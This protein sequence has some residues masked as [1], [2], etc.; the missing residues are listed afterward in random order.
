[1]TVSLSVRV[2]RGLQSV[3]LSVSLA[4]AAAAQPP[5][6]LFQQPPA[7]EQPEAETP[8][9][10]SPSA[11]QPTTPA[12]ADSIETPP[13]PADAATP[14]DEA[15]AEEP[16]I[17]DDA[18]LAFQRANVAISQGDVTAALAALDEAIS[19][20]PDYYDAFL[21][22]NLVYRISGDFEESLRAAAQA[23]A[24]DP[25][26]PNGYLN[27]ALTYIEMKDY[28]KALADVDES[29]KYGPNNPQAF[30]VAGVVHE[31]L[32]DWEKMLD[33]YGKAIEYAA[34]MPATLGDSLMQR[35]IA[36]FHL[37]EY[38]LAKLD[39][40]QAGMYG[41][42]ANG[43]S[44]RWR[45]YVY[46]VQG[47]Y[48]RAIR[49]FD[50]AVKANP[51]NAQAYRNRGMAYLNMAASQPRFHR[52]GLI[53]AVA[54]FN[55]AIRLKPHDAQLYYRRGVAYD[56]LGETDSARSSYQTAVKLDPKLTEAANQLA[57]SQAVEYW[58]DE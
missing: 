53:Q 15:A 14:A 55:Q 28:P 58:Y 37:G 12:P 35:G 47:D 10:P 5:E 4:T 8:A 18:L 26:A 16:Q 36:W 33:A 3:G 23:L 43:E 22:R 52:Q 39:F 24:I 57:S 27:R 34:I 1:M 48:V 40:E 6:Y 11:A 44:N 56:R 19:L 50:R 31:K 32:K 30:I 21:L 17:N 54:S 38:E 13:T 29:L 51:G 2:I 20:Q 7:T 9:T 42:G 45:G 25:E 46:A 41:G 49:W